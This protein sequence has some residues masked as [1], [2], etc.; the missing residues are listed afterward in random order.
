MTDAAPSPAHAAIDAA[1]I[2]A[3]SMIGAL[4]H[5]TDLL[6]DLT[7]HVVETLRADRKILTCGN[8]GSA[9]EALHLAEELVGRYRDTRRA[10]PAICLC[11]DATALTCIANDWDYAEVFARQIEAHGRAGDLLI[12]LSTSGKSPS[13]LRALERARKIGVSTMGLLGPAGSP[14]ESL[15]DRVLTLDNVPPPRIQEA[16]LITIHLIL[17]RIDD[18]A[19]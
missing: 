19:L 1:L 9:A 6:A 17:D 12:A 5:R 3:A 15:C 18:A 13:V 14:A 16:H 8:G 2:D 7:N 11:A 4:R 10:L